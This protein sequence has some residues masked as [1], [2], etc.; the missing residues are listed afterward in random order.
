MNYLDR[1]FLATGLAAALALPSSALAADQPPTW[2]AAASCT[3]IEAKLAPYLDD[4]EEAQ[5]ATACDARDAA[6]VPARN[7][8]KA[9]H[10]VYVKARIDANQAYLDAVKAAEQLPQGTA[11]RE[12]LVAARN[13]R[14]AAIHTARVAYGKVA[15]RSREEI[16]QAREEFR[17]TV[18]TLL[19]A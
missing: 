17:T 1:F 9:A 12:A 6:V 15:E 11:R 2:S 14:R 10:D 8:R 18:S 7:D 19:S 13:T 16:H 5:L 4:A 3:T